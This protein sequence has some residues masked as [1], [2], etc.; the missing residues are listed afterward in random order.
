MSGEK[1]TVS[2]T[3]VQRA[4]V[5]LKSSAGL[6]VEELNKAMNK[7]TIDAAG[8]VKADKLS[9]QVLKVRTGRLR[10]SITPATE[11]TGALIVGKVGTNVEYGAT[12][13]NGFKGNIQVKDHKRLLV[14]AFGIP[15]KN[16]H[17]ISVRAHTRKVDIKPRPFL[18]PTISERYPTYQEWFALAVQ[19]GAANAAKS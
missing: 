13:E 7:A 15:V 6:V 16:P 4:Q 3:G 5:V 11:D 19:R 17:K 9:G 14:K 18:A 10:R 1:V 2:L 8:V 12:W